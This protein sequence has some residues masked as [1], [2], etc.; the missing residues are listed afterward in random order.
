[1]L[2]LNRT[3]ELHLGLKKPDGEITDK[4]LVH[5]AAIYRLDRK[6]NQTQILVYSGLRLLSPIF[7]TPRPTPPHVS[8]QTEPPPPRTYP[9]PNYDQPAGLFDTSNYSADEL[10]SMFNSPPPSP[11]SSP[12]PTPM[13]MPAPVSFGAPTRTVHDMPNRGSKDAPKTF[14]GSYAEVQDF[15]HSYDRLLVKYRVTEAFYQC[16]C[17]L[18]YCGTDV[19]DFIRASEYYLRQDWP[20]LR[21][22][23][24]TCY[25]A[26]RATSRYKPSDITVYTLK[27]TKKAFRNLTQW[28]RYLRNYKT[29][30]GT[31]LNQGQITREIRDGYF[32]LGIQIDLRGQLERQILLTHPGINREKQYPMAIVNDAAAW[33]FSRSRVETMMV[34]ASAYGIAEEDD[35][36]DREQE[37]DSD[38][39][40]SDQSDLE[41]H[42]RKKK[43]R[44]QRKERTDPKTRPTLKSALKTEGSADEVTG[45]I[46]QLNKMSIDDPEYSP[47]FYKVLTMDKTVIAAKCVQPPRIQQWGEYNRAPSRNSNRP[48]SINSSTTTTTAP[49]PAT[50]PNNIP[51]RSTT[52]DNRGCYGCN[53]EG[54][55]M[56]E[57]PELQ[58]ML[59][60]GTLAY[61]GESSR[62]RLKDGTWI[63]RSQGESIV[64][65]AKRLSGPTVMFSTYDSEPDKLH[66]QHSF[67]MNPERAQYI[68]SYSASEE[69][70]VIEDSDSGYQTEVIEATITEADRSGAEDESPGQRVYL[71][72]PRKHKEQSDVP[73]VQSAE[74]TVPSTRNARR[75]VFDGV[76]VPSKDEV[77]N[78]PTKQIGRESTAPSS[79]DPRPLAPPITKSPVSLPEIKPVDARQV[80]FDVPR[81]DVDTP[82]PDVP[83]I[84][85]YTKKQEGDVTIRTRIPTP[86]PEREEPINGIART[87]RQSELQ[88]TVD[89]N[90]VLDRLLNLTLPLSVGEA[91]AL[92]KE[93]RNGIQ[94]KTRLK[95][96]KAVVIGRSS[97]H[98]ILANWT[99][100]RSEGILIKIEMETCGR[101][102]FAIIDTGS[103]L[104]VVR[105]DVAALVIH[106][107]VDMTCVTSM[108]DANGGKGQ[109][110]GKINEVEFSCGGVTTKTDLWVSQQ[111]PFELLLGRP[112]QRSNLVTIDE[113]EEGTYLVFKDPET[114]RPRYELLAIPHD[115]GMDAYHYL[116]PPDLLAYIAEGLDEKR[117]IT[118]SI[119]STPPPDDEPNKQLPGSTG[120]GTA[121]Y[122]IRNASIELA[123]ESVQ[124][125]RVSLALVSLII[126]G[127]LICV[128]AAISKLIE[129]GTRIKDGGLPD[130]PRTSPPTIFTLTKPPHTVFRNTPVPPI[131]P[132]RAA[133]PPADALTAED[134]TQVLSR[135]RYGSYGPLDEGDPAA[136]PSDIIERIADK[137]WHAHLHD[138]QMHVRPGFLAA[139]QTFYLGRNL[140]D[141]QQEEHHG[142]MLNARMLLHNPETGAPGSQN[143]HAYFVFKAVPKDPQQ[144]WD[145]EVPYAAEAPI[146][147]ILLHY[148]DIAVETTQGAGES[149]PKTVQTDED[150]ASMPAH[151][152]EPEAEPA[153]CEP[154]M[155]SPRTRQ[156]YRYVLLPAHKAPP[157]DVSHMTNIGTAQSGERVLRFTLRDD[158]PVAPAGGTEAPMRFDTPIP[159]FCLLHACPPLDS[160]KTVCPP[161]TDIL[162]ESAEAQTQ[163][164]TESS[165]RRQLMAHPRYPVAKDTAELVADMIAHSS[166]SAA[167]PDPGAI[168]RARQRLRNRMETTMGEE[169]MTERKRKTVA[170]PPPVT[171]IGTSAA[172]RLEIPV[173][174]TR[175]PLI[176][177]ERFSSSPEPSGPDST[178][179]AN[180]LS[181][182]DDAMTEVSVDSDESDA[183]PRLLIDTAVAEAQRQLAREQPRP[184]PFVGMLLA[185]PAP[186][187][188]RLDS[189][190][191]LPVLN[192]NYSAPRKATDLFTWTPMPGASSP[193]TMKSPVRMKS[194]VKAKHPGPRVPLPGGRPITIFDE[195]LNQ[196]R[197]PRPLTSMQHRRVL[198]ELANEEVFHE[199]PMPDYPDSPASDSS[200]PS[201]CSPDAFDRI[202][203]GELNLS[204]D[205]PRLFPAAAQS[206]FGEPSHTPTH[207]FA[208]IPIESVSLDELKEALHSIYHE[209]PHDEAERRCTI[210]KRIENWNWGRRQHIK[211]FR[212]NRVLIAVKPIEDAIQTII[213]YLAHL[214]DH[215]AM[216]HG[217]FQ[218]MQYIARL[219]PNTPADEIIRL[220]SC[221]VCSFIDAGRPHAYN[222]D[223]EDALRTVD[224]MA[225]DPTAEEPRVEISVDIPSSPRG[226]RTRERT[227]NN[228]ALRK[229][230][231]HLAAVKIEYDRHKK[232]VSHF[233]NARLGVLAGLYQL[234]LYTGQ[235]LWELDLS[236]LHRTGPSPLPFLHDSEYAQLRLFGDACDAFGDHAIH[237]LIDRLCRLRFR[238]SAL[239]T[240]FLQ[241]GFMDPTYSPRPNSHWTESSDSESGE[242]DLY[243]FP[244]PGASIIPHFTARPSDLAF[245]YQAAQYESYAPS[246][247]PSAANSDAGRPVSAPP[248]F[249]R[250][251]PPAY[252]S[253]DAILEDYR[254]ECASHTFANCRPFLRTYYVSPHA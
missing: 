215:D 15:I 2:T 226:D 188:P 73:N 253:N 29:I 49:A 119:N 43:R 8:R 123:F 84:D 229:G 162:E 234:D 216:K 96:V 79:S 201:L 104:D 147:K 178:T 223:F 21:R 37:D 16:E 182:L 192:F 155:I 32:W 83:K 208:D 166:P 50:Y 233:S 242:E 67:Y 159:P 231:V 176:S 251:D 51:L 206:T 92:S 10:D 6:P 19:K 145:I 156:R 203:H 249:N 80:R 1:M 120:T 125:C 149:R 87:G 126:G 45:L 69:E 28:K 22:E 144:T 185:P 61:D 116:R 13:H 23:I 113:R 134:E 99:W 190:A 47:V 167:H 153:T 121:F 117:G 5:V 247:V 82:M 181:F 164:Q 227:F 195:Y 128:E 109:L 210:W 63:R 76:Q 254:H 152:P 174:R 172:A 221:L 11:P 250:T 55:R 207:S 235:R 54:H 122:N 141:N 56:N 66:P 158:G 44:K 173:F 168:D 90:G 205:A 39:Y 130:S 219:S 4:P 95:N 71:T 143:G 35:D 59:Q 41:A 148:A 34:N 94:E 175:G 88:S 224:S 132:P 150:I 111:A 20:R 42:R 200:M 246:N 101:K 211:I 209:Y 146:R 64:D 89:I 53:K 3:I 70:H 105:A 112:W 154:G 236:L 197:S 127:I 165:N 198:Q 114:R 228:E 237:D 214:F 124:A 183:D 97:S 26:E 77:R 245:Y 24:L 239:F 106:R 137:E 46:R 18:D 139:P 204:T 160:V 252:T 135:E 138:H 75:L 232:D 86:G 194:P 220:Q 7:R 62:L 193:A 186:T 110:R 136:Q 191:A 225:L 57:C 115:A 85:K 60:A 129:K 230:P 187:P 103:Q 163:K 65:A 72:V 241:C 93:I 17:I 33:Y 218:L 157:F 38:E 27:T 52:P 217:D 36:S 213:T 222:D 140:Q 98:P 238:K 244:R 240:H 40:S 189:G 243:R 12:E 100:Q 199:L 248:S 102:V 118:A 202:E 131:M 133:K 180:S 48:V 142:V 177:R 107:P 212:S 68:D 81:V 169:E 58:A 161:L 184:V 9:A 74:R 25:D 170:A 179:Y 91:F 151:T 31:L 78:R 108:N 171:E 30:S 196:V 14:K